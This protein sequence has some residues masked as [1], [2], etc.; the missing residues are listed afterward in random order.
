MLSQRVVNEP[1]ARVLVTDA[2]STADVS[3]VGEKDDD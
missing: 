2:M 1:A 3:L